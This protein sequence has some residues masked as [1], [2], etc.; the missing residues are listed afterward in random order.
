LTLASI[1][2]FQS[3]STTDFLPTK[4][5]GSETLG[6]QE[7]AEHQRCCASLTHCSWL[8]VHTGW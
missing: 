4:Q 3:S 7:S 6:E 1:S 8:T 5:S 2:S